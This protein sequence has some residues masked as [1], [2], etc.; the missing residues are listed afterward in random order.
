[1]IG[2]NQKG[3]SLVEALVALGAAVLIITSIAVAVITSVNNAV[4]SKNQNLATQYAQQA[5]DTLRHQS[6]S[7]WTSFSALDGSYCLS[8]NSTNLI[9]A[10]LGCSLNINDSNNNPFFIRTIQ[11]THV[12]SLPATANCAGNILANVSVSWRDAKCTNTLNSYCHSVK[13]DT[14]LANINSVSAP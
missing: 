14:C 5:I 4:F 9:P 6:I 3:Q 13:L 7:N 12:A 10:G 1:M 8:Q 11:I 2:I